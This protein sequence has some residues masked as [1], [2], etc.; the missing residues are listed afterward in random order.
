LRRTEKKNDD[1]SLDKGSSSEIL[2]REE[3]RRARTWK[4]WKFHFGAFSVFR[5][6]ANVESTQPGA[7]IL[8]RK[9]HN[10]GTHSSVCVFCG[11]KFQEVKTE[12]AAAGMSVKKTYEKPLLNP[13][14]P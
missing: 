6:Y 14:K 4:P 10:V 5:F 7:M 1:G 3:L 11:E 13:E 9:W 8:N 12:P 2:R